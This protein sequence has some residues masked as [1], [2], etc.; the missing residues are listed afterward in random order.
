MV[1]AT[2]T[3]TV[4][5]SPYNSMYSCP[6]ANDFFGSRHFGQNSSN[7]QNNQQVTITPRNEATALLAQYQ[8][9]QSGN[10]MN[11]YAAGTM[12]ANQ[13]SGSCGDFFSPYTSFTEG[14]I[15]ASQRFGPG[16]YGFAPTNMFYYG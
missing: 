13:F 16:G 10:Y 4:A 2:D 3:S 7:Y 11:S 12:I 6:M 14:D 5:N 8:T 1:S 15:F 9:A